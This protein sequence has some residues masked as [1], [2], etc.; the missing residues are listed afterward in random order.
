MKIEYTIESQELF[1]KPTYFPDDMIKF[2]ITNRWMEYIVPEENIN[3][4]EKKIK[5]SNNILDRT[6]PVGILT[7]VINVHKGNPEKLYLAFGY[8]MV[9]GYKRSSAFNWLPIYYVLKLKKITNTTIQFEILANC[10]PASVEAGRTITYRID[11]GSS[12]S[13]YYID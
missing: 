4:L 13:L 1:L 5:Y 3:E 12:L 8:P 7:D 6:K 9:K 11:K 10:G 2:G